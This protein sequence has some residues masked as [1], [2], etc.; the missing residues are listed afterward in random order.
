MISDHI[1]SVTMNKN[2]C[3][4]HTHIVTCYSVTLTLMKTVKVKIQIGIIDR[5]L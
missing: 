2:I 4:V 5:Y 3:Y 1:A